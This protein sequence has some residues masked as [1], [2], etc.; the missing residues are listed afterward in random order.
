MCQNQ[1][2]KW[3]HPD[4]FRANPPHEQMLIPQ[5]FHILRKKFRFKM[6]WIVMDKDVLISTNLQQT[7]IEQLKTDT[8]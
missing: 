5:E 1:L 2:H 7:N 6:K 3:S 8:G 4:R